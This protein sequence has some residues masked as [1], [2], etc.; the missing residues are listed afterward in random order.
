MRYK[1]YD[2]LTYSDYGH[3]RLVAYLIDPGYG[4]RRGMRD[5]ICLAEV[6]PRKR[7]PYVRRSRE[8]LMRIGPM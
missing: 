6:T 1:V 7:E 4:E 5:N 8:A 2:N 3:L